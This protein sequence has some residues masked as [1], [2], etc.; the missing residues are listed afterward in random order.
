MTTA[1]TKPSLFAAKGYGMLKLTACLWATY[2]EE[3]IVVNSTT[4]IGFALSPDI[5]RERRKFSLTFVKE[6]G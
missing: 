5:I 1:W 3:A 2:T 4:K 6:S